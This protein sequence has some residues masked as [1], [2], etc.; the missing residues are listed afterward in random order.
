ME[1][2]GWIVIKGVI[3]SMGFF[4]G[5]LILGHLREIALRVALSQA[6]LG[7]LVFFGGWLGI[8][9]VDS[10]LRSK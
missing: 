3:G 5:S 10:K 6:I 2:R 1:K 4:V 8:S 9:A 7:A